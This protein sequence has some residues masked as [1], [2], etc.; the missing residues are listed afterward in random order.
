[1]TRR[2]RAAL[3]L[4][5]VAISAAVVWRFTTLPP[6][7]ANQAVARSTPDEKDRLG[8]PHSPE[9]LTHSRDASAPS[10]AASVE[11]L[12][13]AVARPDAWVDVGHALPGGAFEVSWNVF[14]NDVTGAFATRDDTVLLYF[15]E[16]RTARIMANASRAILPHGVAPLSDPRAPA[17]DETF[18]AGVW[19]THPR[20]LPRL[21]LLEPGQRPAHAFTAADAIPAA[22]I[23]VVGPDGSAAAG[24]RVRQQALPLPVEAATEPDMTNVARRALVR[25]ANADEF[26]VV[27]RLP[28]GG[29]VR[30]QAAH[31]GLAADVIVD[32][33]RADLL[34]TLGSRWSLSG[35]VLGAVDVGPWAMALVTAI[36]K[37]GRVVV[38]SARVA[39]ASFGPLVIPY[40]VDVERYDVELSFGH[41]EPV[42]KP[43]ARPAPGENVRIDFEVSPGH[44]AWVRVVDMTTDAAVEGALVELRWRSPEG[45]P[46]SI[47]ARTGPTGWADFVGLPSRVDAWSVRAAGYGTRHS[48]DG[49]EIAVEEPAYV[50]G[51]PTAGRI[52]GR[53]DFG[54]L[55]PTDFVVQHDIDGQWPLRDSQWFRNA[56][57]GEFEISDVAPGPKSIHAK[58]G[59]RTSALVRI[60]VDEGRDTPVDLRLLP[61]ATVRGRVIDAVDGAPVADAR[62]RVGLAGSHHREAAT[63][64]DGWRSDA[65]GHFQ[66]ADVP[67][68]Q[69]AIRVSSDRHA[70]YLS[71]LADLAAGELTD[72]GDIPLRPRIGVR[73]RLIGTVGDP[74]AYRV[75]LQ[76]R[77]ETTRAFGPDRLA[78]MDGAS[79]GEHAILFHPT[80]EEDV[81]AHAIRSESLAEVQMHVWPGVATVELVDEQD[82]PVL[83]GGEIELMWHDP[84]GGIVVRKHVFTRAE[85]LSTAGLPATRIGYVAVST[86]R[87]MMGAGSVEF[88]G[89]S[90]IVVRFSSERARVRVVDTV[91][92]P[93]PHVWV[94]LDVVQSGALVSQQLDLTDEEG[95]AHFAVTAAGETYVKAETMDERRVIARR[96]RLPSDGSQLDL[97]LDAHHTLRV[98]AVSDGVGLVNA[99]YRLMFPYGAQSIRVGS[100]DLA[101]GVQLARVGPDPL[102]LEIDLPGHWPVSRLLAPGAEHVVEAPRLVDW[103]LRVVDANGMGVAGAAIELEHTTLR[104][105]HRAR[106]ELGGSVRVWMDAGLY[107]TAA[108]T[109]DSF[110]R[111]RLQGLPKGT[112]RVRATVSSE[113]WSTGEVQVGGVTAVATLVVP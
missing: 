62:I 57:S 93:L 107:S 53:L 113:R 78:V 61:V 56:R 19:V 48:S 35:H 33:E 9:A 103:E 28:M 12:R 54:D 59:T 94:L 7:G 67:V 74:A 46:L 2:A 68:T 21:L 11:N 111:L 37:D 10:T 82:T 96:V 102:L 104:H 70:T 38:A 98:R 77:L 88:D 69:G 22:A 25:E 52:T 40:E 15:L 18:G 51:I 95:V 14:D 90:P 76:G 43:L 45:R 44:L 36:R 86:D 110:G 6:R 106:G 31:G 42:V 65:G 24:A 75:A 8:S 99:G 27:P 49:L 97:V 105:Y 26:G 47:R 73:A 20:A 92:K 3:L 1:M 41:V 89:R 50:I 80:G 91:G 112:Y 55:E 108:L 85:R 5:V 17:I 58:S 81:H 100:T 23:R 72:L 29:P 101:G 13:T 63:I 64:S 66:I 39:E 71:A 87:A 79:L 109:T 60:S 83:F 30:I 84:Q 34:I 4:C 32:D 16:D